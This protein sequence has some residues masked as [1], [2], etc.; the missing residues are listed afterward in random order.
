MRVTVI[1]VAGFAA[2]FSLGQAAAAD[3]KAVYEKTCAG[4]HSAMSPKVTGEKAKWDALLKQGKPALAAS[5]IK[6]KGAMP[7][8]GG[9][10]SDADVKAALDYMVTQIK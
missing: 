1:A 10:A 2:L 9:A 4:C 7:P 5:V 8:K 6:G 3:G